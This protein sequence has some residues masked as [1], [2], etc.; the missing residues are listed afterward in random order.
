MGTRTLTLELPEEIAELLGPPEA[1]AAKAREMV[2][3]ELL[4]EAR[5]GQS[6]AAQLL[7]ISRAELLDR[8][9]E[10]RIPSGP[11]TAEEAQREI[12]EMRRFLNSAGAHGGG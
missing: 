12:E 1:A 11:E 2:V 5:I 10:Q 9:A 7:G 8:M 4:R 3:L 6:M